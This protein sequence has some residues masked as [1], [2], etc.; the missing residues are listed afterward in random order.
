MPLKNRLTQLEA[1]I[2]PRC[3]RC[4]CELSCEYC[5]YGI[6]VHT[7][8]DETLEQIV[9]D[10]VRLELERHGI[11]FFRLL[12][13]DLQKLTRDELWTLKVLLQKMGPESPTGG[14]HANTQSPD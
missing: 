8:S 13:C 2:A 5:A 9:V 6:A 11:N 14:P 10:G 1:R 4:K 3:P 12:G 7:A